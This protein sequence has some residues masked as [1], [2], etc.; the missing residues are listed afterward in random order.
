MLQGFGFRARRL[1]ARIV[2]SEQ[3]TAADGKLHNKYVL[4]E[5]RG[6]GWN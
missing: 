3:R 5:A 1:I 2:F 4:T 6:D